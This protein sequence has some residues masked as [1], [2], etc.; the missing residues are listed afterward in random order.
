MTLR[1][2]N[3]KR[4]WCARTG[5][6]NLSD[7][8]YLYDPE[9]KYGK[10]YNPAVLPFDSIA[11]MPC[12]ALLGEPGIGKSIAM[13]ADR[14]IIDEKIK[15]EGG[16]IIWIDL[17]SY[18]SEDRLV[19]N[20][21]ENQQFASWVEGNQTLHIF[22]DS[23][24]ECLLRVDTI[25]TLLIDELKN[26]PLDRLNLRI[27]CRTADWPMALENGLRDLWGN[28][29]FEAYELV[30]LRRI[31]IIEAARKNGVNP[32]SFLIE[33]DR[34]E[35]VPL[36]I[37]PVTL[38]FLLNTFKRNGQFPSKKSELYLQGC[39]I[40]CEDISESRRAAR[41][42][43]ALSAKQRLGVAARIAALT[44][45]GNR[46]AVWMDPDMG[47]VPEEDITVAQISG[48]TE[49]VAEQ[50]I[51]VTE[52][53]VR[54][55]I[56]SGLFS[57]RGPQR[58]GW[59]HQTYAEFLAAWYLIQRGVTVPQILSL[60]LHSEDPAKKLVPHLHETV[61]WLAGMNPDIFRMIMESEPNVLLRSDV[62]TAEEGNRSR[63]VGNLLKLYEEDKLIDPIDMRTRY[64]KL[65]HKDIT[66]QLREYISKPSKG[67]VARRVAIDIAEECELKSLQSD[68]ASVA[69]NSSNPL[70]IRTHAA[71]YVARFADAET[72]IRLKA[73]ATTLNPDDVDDELKGCALSALWPDL[74]EPRELL[75][76]IAPL[77][78]DNFVGAYYMFIARELVNRLP[79]NGL[80]VALT[81]V[82][83]Q[84]RKH[85][86]GHCFEK[87]MDGIMLKGWEY[88]D[89][90]EVLESFARASLSRLKLHDEIVSHS[91]EQ[92]LR[93]Q[94]FEEDSGRRKLLRAMIPMLIDPDKDAFWLA[95]SRTP[96]VLNKDFEWIIDQLE[97]SESQQSTWAALLECIFDLNNS[98]HINVLLE[99]SQRNHVLREKFASLIEPIDIFSPAGQEMKSTF[100]KRKKLMERDKDPLLDPPPK[101]RIIHLLDEFESGNNE[102]WWRLNM[103][104][105]LEPNS[106]YYNDDLKGDLTSLPG[107]RDAN[108]VTRSRILEAARKYVLNEECKKHEWLGKDVM[109]RP[110]YAGYRALRLLLQQDPHF[111]S[112]LSG[113]A[114]QRWAA[115][116][117]AF[118]ESSD[119]EEKGAQ[120]KLLRLAYQHAPEETIETLMT[121]ID[122]ENEKHEHIFITSK[123]ENC[124]DENLACKLF[125]KAKESN[126]KP[127][128]LGSLL[129]ELL[130]HE[131]PEGKAFAE[132]LLLGHA[133]PDENEQARA[134]VA[135]G[136]LLGHAK[137]SAWSTVWPI[138]KENSKFGRTVIESVAYHGRNHPIALETLA[139]TELAALF[140]WLAHEYPYSSDPK[141]EGARF[142][143]G[144]DSVVELKSAV[145]N[146]LENRGTF[147]ACDALRQIASELPELDWLKWNIQRAEE[148]ARRKTWIPPAPSHIL[149]ITGDHKLRLVQDG[150]E[151]LGAVIDSLHRLES[152]VQGETPASR[153]IWD[154]VGKKYRPCEE[155]DFSDYVKRHL[156]EDLKQRG[157][158]IN[159]EVRI[160]RGERTDIHIDAVTKSHGKKVYD[161]LTCVIEAKGCWNP[162]LKTA[163]ETQ[164]V[165]R[166]LRGSHCQHGLYLVGW[167]NCEKWDD[168]DRRKS[169][170]PD[171]T[172]EEAQLF[173]NSQAYQLSVGGLTIKALV[174]DG[175]LK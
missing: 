30:P 73:L 111:L 76:V 60:L 91:N 137:G 101:E 20:L 146:H 80:T 41:L 107:W 52:D 23:L 124:W 67:I 142:L 130:D 38:N 85:S 155:N 8:G 153:D 84:G 114:W 68:I 149:R 28:E 39:E 148:N 49:A 96:V 44:V 115:I 141:F 162:E 172:I 53:A 83:K 121:I 104:M 154:N 145:L 126:L 139:E 63:L 61:A 165:N 152:K 95:Y 117:L 109:Y 100:I 129:T 2:Y 5:K 89:V 54:E 69:I 79:L 13:Q 103:E 150:K 138:I 90:P 93:K 156:D 143:S 147:Q 161:V 160:H 6:I 144:R 14:K 135:A 116:I 151:L 19:R 56:S 106:R 10:I 74:I 166:Y 26:Y 24:D 88:L 140:V 42:T 120:E 170:T 66:D 113:D 35:S 29:N 34:T 134:V 159:R 70:P 171:M 57:S 45:F 169:K 48:E 31:D 86:L 17:R 21:F 75:A 64:R 112:S 18:A 71:H 62:A 158:I 97:S 119:E 15:Q 163:M 133:S 174:I 33:I 110:A 72:K 132:S 25:A 1:I 50:I 43:G 167:F 168:E 173:F 94:L 175:A 82:E 22:L 7:G 105:T 77:K 122:R 65:Y 46:Y 131:I 157:I 55:T 32:D 136:V 3:W 125:E 87:L 164:L 27:A 47:D 37:I 16:E 127:G 11:G 12:L 92:D 118:P 102:A 78:K 4:F 59:S 58:M 9:S 99:A 51:Q 128:C 36:A 98:N 108:E 123:L 81:W 40:L